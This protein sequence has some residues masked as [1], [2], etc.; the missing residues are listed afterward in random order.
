MSNDN[1]RDQDRVWQLM[2][3]IGFAMLV[4]HDGDKLRARPMS[5]YLARDR[6]ESG[7]QSLVRRCRQPEIR[8]GYRHC[9]R[10]QRPY[11]DQAAIFDAS[12]SLVGQRRRPEYPRLKDHARRCGILGFAGFSHQLCENGCG[13]GDRPAAGCRREP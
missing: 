5:A 11:Q 12:E 13:G 6:P 9:R 10:F 2:K 7:H 4:T 8:L 3:E 1:A